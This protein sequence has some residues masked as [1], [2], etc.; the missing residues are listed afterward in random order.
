M[1]E[2]SCDTTFSDKTAVVTGGASGIGESCVKLLAE[3]GATVVVCDRNVEAGEAVAEK[4]GGLAVP[5]DVAV[6]EEIRLVAD[7]IEADVGPVDLLV[8]SAGIIQSN[9]A[10]PEELEVVEWDAIVDID[11]RG[12]YLCCTNFAKH[13]CKRGNG[14]IVTIASVMGLRSGPFH[15][16]GPA[17][18]G[19]VHLTQ[20]LAA[21]WGRSGV[22][23]NA[24]SPGYVLTPVLERAIED[25][26]RDVSVMEDSSASGRMVRPDEIAEA[27]CF[28]LSDAASAIT[29]INLP[30]DNGWLSAINWHTYGGV[31]AKR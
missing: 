27:T 3:R 7:K 16:Y 14:S 24:I 11:L 6:P 30:V 9:P 4:Y 13:M 2:L 20:T 23:V 22:R 10:P 29:G 1:P 19:V 28:L 15:A 5:L 17:K 26:L 8:T 31:R 18:A 12:T 25:G 21:E